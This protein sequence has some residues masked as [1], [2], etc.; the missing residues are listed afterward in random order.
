MRC[1]VLRRVFLVAT[2]AIS[3]GLFSQTYT[4]PGLP[5]GMNQ[6]TWPPII[7]A[8]P[9]PNIYIVGGGTYGTGVYVT[10]GGTLPV[11]G[12][13]FYLTSPG[14]LPVQGTGIS[15]ASRQGIS[16]ESPLQT[17]AV[18]FLPSVIPGMPIYGAVPAF[19]GPPETAAAELGRLINDLG[20]SYY[21]GAVTAAPPEPSLGEVAAYYKAHR[22]R[23]V[24]TF[25]NADAQRL[26]NTL[27]IPGAA[28]APRPPQAP[29]QTTPP[30][31]PPQQNLPPQ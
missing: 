27:T 30:K 10:P 24:R 23:S 20:P 2:L 31:K 19:A 4:S 26:A 9:S 16:L 11:Q 3:V 28:A 21:A 12:P 14:T 18:T 1:I 29:P 6:P 8:P 25:T 15:F 7:V 13:G 22:P 17:G 5:Q